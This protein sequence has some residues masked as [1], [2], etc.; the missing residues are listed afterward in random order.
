MELRSK[1]ERLEQMLNR[2]SEGREARRRVVGFGAVY[3]ISKSSRVF[4]ANNVRSWATPFPLSCCVWSRMVSLWSMDNCV[5]LLLNTE[6]D[7]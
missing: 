3:Y 2:I 1:G 7:V 6:V 5:K 4:M